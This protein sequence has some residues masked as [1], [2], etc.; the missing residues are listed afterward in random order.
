MAWFGHPTTMYVTSGESKIFLRFPR[1]VQQLLSYIML[2]LSSVGTHDPDC[3]GSTCMASL[4]GVPCRAV[5][6]YE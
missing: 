2:R 1:T 3:S 4:C 5:W 6:A